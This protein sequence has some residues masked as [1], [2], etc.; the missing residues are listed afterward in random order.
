MTDENTSEETINDKILVEG[1]EDHKAVEG[2]VTGWDGDKIRAD[3]ELL[4]NSISR[5]HTSKYGMKQKKTQDNPR[6]QTG[7]SRAREPLEKEEN[8]DDLPPRP[9]TTNKTKT[10]LNYNTKATTTVG[11]S[12]S[13]P[14]STPNAAQ[15]GVVGNANELKPSTTDDNDTKLEG[16]IQ[17][18][19]DKEKTVEEEEDNEEPL[20]DIT[21]KKSNE[22]I[23]LEVENKNRIWFKGRKVALMEHIHFQNTGK[24]L[25]EQISS[26]YKI[27]REHDEKVF[28]L[29][30]RSATR[31]DLDA[32]ARTKADKTVID[33]E[34]A[35]FA[36][37]TQKQLREKCD[38]D[39]AKQRLKTKVEWVGLKDA[40][41]GFVR[42]MMFEIIAQKLPEAVEETKAGLVL[43]I[44]RM[45]DIDPS[46][47]ADMEAVKALRQE[48]ERLQK[49]VAESDRVHTEAIRSFTETV[50]LVRAEVQ[51]SAEERLQEQIDFL[52]KACDQ[53]LDDMTE[54]MEALM[55]TSRER[56]KNSVQSLKEK[57][58]RI[59]LRLK[60]EG[61]EIVNEFAAECKKEK[62]KFVADVQAK[63]ASDMKE[64]HSRV[65]GCERVCA[66]ANLVISTLKQKM[67]EQDNFVKQTLKRVDTCE[68]Q[69]VAVSNSMGE[70]EKDC[71]D[72]RET[73]VQMKRDL[74]AVE[75]VFEKLSKSVDI[76]SDKLAN[77]KEEAEENKKELIKKIEMMIEKNKA[78]GGKIQGRVRA[79]EDF[80]KN[81]QR[82]NDLRLQDLERTIFDRLHLV[83]QHQQQ[84]VKDFQKNLEKLRKEMLGK[85]LKK[86]KDIDNTNKNV[87]KQGKLV[88]N[89]QVSFKE[90]RVELQRL[91]KTEDKVEKLLASMENGPNGIAMAALQKAEHV[92]KQLDEQLQHGVFVRNGTGDPMQNQAF[93]TLEDDPPQEEYVD[94]II[95]QLRDLHDE[96]INT[97]EAFK[98]IDNTL[99]STKTERREIVKQLRE[100]KKKNDKVTASKLGEQLDRLDEDIEKISVQHEDSKKELDSANQNVEALKNVAIAGGKTE[101]QLANMIEET[102]ETDYPFEHS[103]SAPQHAG[104]SR[105][106]STGSLMVS[107]PSV[108]KSRDRLSTRT[109][110]SRGGTGSR[111]SQIGGIVGIEIEALQVEMESE[112]N[113][114]MELETE[115]KDTRRTQDALLHTQEQLRE[116]IHG[117]KIFLETETQN[118]I[119]KVM[120]RVEALMETNQ[121]KQIEDMENQRLRLEKA[122]T[123]MRKDQETLIKKLKDSNSTLK[124]QLLSSGVEFHMD[125]IDDHDDVKTSVHNENS[126]RNIQLQAEAQVML[127][128]IQI[129]HRE[130]MEKM[131]EE[132]LVAKKH[133]GQE[134]I[135]ELNDVIANMR[136]MHQET[137]AEHQKDMERMKA[138]IAQHSLKVDS[139]KA[140]AEAD[141]AETNHAKRLME[142]QTR[143]LAELDVNQLAA[144]LND[145]VEKEFFGNMEI[146]FES[147]VKQLEEVSK[148]A[149]EQHLEAVAKETEKHIHSLKAASKEVRESHEKH[150]SGHRENILEMANSMQEQHEKH[151]GE[152]QGVVSEVHKSL[153]DINENSKYHMQKFGI[154]SQQ[155]QMK[156]SDF[157]KIHKREE[158]KQEYRHLCEMRKLQNMMMKD[159]KNMEKELQVA[160][161]DAEKEHEQFI[162]FTAKL[163]HETDK[164]KRKYEQQLAD[165]QVRIQNGF[166]SKEFAKN[167]MAIYAEQET[168]S[169]IQ[170]TGMNP[171]DPDHIQE[172]PQ[173]AHQA[174]DPKLK[175]LSV[176]DAIAVDS[177]EAS[178]NV[179]IPKYSR[180]NSEKRVSYSPEM[181]TSYTMHSSNYGESEKWGKS[182][183]GVGNTPMLS[184]DN[185]ISSSDQ[186]R[187]VATS[188]EGRNI[189]MFIH[190]TEFGLNSTKQLIV[191]VH[192]RLSSEIVALQ[193]IVK[194]FS[195]E[196]D[197][198]RRLEAFWSQVGDLKNWKDKV[199]DLTE[200]NKT[201]LSELR[202]TRQDHLILQSP[203]RTSPNKYKVRKNNKKKNMNERVML[204]NV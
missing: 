46:Q 135:H 202:R 145:K 65:K 48:C 124:K 84:N 63:Y 92:Q 81:V 142:E 90:M 8:K 123:E 31:G 87:K 30:E 182:R 179:S 64:L 77:M 164:M 13:R 51:E 9:K 177:R 32:L 96:K 23:K 36:E 116:Q 21:S 189:D 102:E 190:K 24:S 88:H 83:G 200:E 50:A 158:S 78:S 91:L 28:N 109:P 34:S 115:I 139:Y 73:E 193:D 122:N 43:M 82:K 140:V 187:L 5:P 163:S 104:H 195:K 157:E 194:R 198:S 94:P 175:I 86:A 57:N 146:R 169:R 69:Q 16:K 199:V 40:V 39:Y 27:V 89:V 151:M 2:A 136:K 14:K 108:P 149:Q 185:N 47:K 59:M 159:R 128:D 105:Q 54:K 1:K 19:E 22:K 147:E 99:K 61:L 38:L 126:M 100:A 155:V 11:A 176:T 196:G 183:D 12:A 66:D 72:L 68:K 97:E 15:Y 20:P 203:I 144:Q 154:Q 35:I 80:G 130:E 113:L 10:L 170:N 161:T 79:L 148:L 58:E 4:F 173:E 119:S 174:G 132:F 56:V 156:I 103:E 172:S 55:E 74:S 112:R 168:L 70:F 53:K 44:Q 141:L 75:N 117:L 49:H 152:V 186:N 180:P 60:E 6:P 93:M 95:E 137:L 3:N 197:V 188:L 7:P 42:P 160:K 121:I 162:K 29:Q 101:K 125:S 26:I 133:V 150:L 127:Q 111:G 98:D 85:V 41:S 76:T 67:R 33:K 25:Q 106:S 204:P 18:E 153:S 62:K 201:L 120:E 171:I 17:P 143:I 134:K 45:F 107:L 52:N 118:S 138:K 71:Q 167:K 192:E 181:P 191:A 129:Q 165:L 131:R 110:K 166:V 178:P 114:R 37:R 184:I